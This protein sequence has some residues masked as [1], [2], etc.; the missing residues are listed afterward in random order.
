[1]VKYCP[2]CRHELEVE[3]KITY[4]CRVCKTAFHITVEYY[5]GKNK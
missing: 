5:L 3:S 2:V 4:W 1:M